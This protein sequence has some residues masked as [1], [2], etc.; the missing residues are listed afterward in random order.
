MTQ[1]EWMIRSRSDRLTVGLLPSFHGG[2]DGF[3]A[4]YNPAST[5]AKRLGGS[6]TNVGAALPQ[7]VR[8]VTRLSSNQQTSSLAGPRREQ[9][10][11]PYAGAQS[12]Q[13]SADPIH[14]CP[15]SKPYF[16]RGE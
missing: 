6:A 2:L 14:R 15:F 4:S 9:K 10:A 1:P 11:Q 8:A 16:S 3:G 5:I 13:K 12:S 7:I